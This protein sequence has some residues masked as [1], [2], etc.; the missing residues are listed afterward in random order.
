MATGKGKPIKWRGQKQEGKTR[1]KAR[2]VP[3]VRLSALYK[4]GDKEKGVVVTGARAVL[5]ETRAQAARINGPKQTFPE[6]A[7]QLMEQ[8]RPFPEQ[9][10]RREGWACEVCTWERY[11]RAVGRAGA[12]VGVGA[13]GYAGYLTRKAS[14]EVRRNYYD[15]LVDVLAEGDFPPEWK[16]WECVLMMKP[17]ED[18]R[19]FGRRRDIWLMPHSLKVASRM[20]MFEYEE[21]ACRYVPASQSGFSK[22]HNACA[23]TLVMR[24]HRERCR[25]QRQG[26]YV[27]YAD[28]GSYFMSICK[29]IMTVAEQWSGTRVEV[30]AVLR[31]MQDELKGRV[32]TAYGMTEPHAMPGVACGQG[33]ECSPVRSKIMA[34]FIQEMATRVCRGYRFGQTGTPQVW[35]ADDSAGGRRGADDG[36]CAGGRRGR[37]RW[38]G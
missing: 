13:D 27:A 29:E 33:H 30:S 26:Y 35:Y 25:E 34:S 17:G 2:G 16:L 19:E 32:E 15:A 22:D 1:W 4:D 23:Q 37:E 36:A 28:M 8:I 3:P 14:G 11:E 31:A 20:L 9:Q 18:P 12:D 6:V 7:K 10:Q 21:V 38:R 24:L 5:D